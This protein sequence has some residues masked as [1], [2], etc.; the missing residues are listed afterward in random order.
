[1]LA[2]RPA[3]T[4]DRTEVVNLLKE[5]SL[6]YIDPP[7]AYLLVLEENT[8]AGCGRLEDHGQFVMVRPLVVA[9]AYRRQGVGSFILKS[10]MPVD[11]PTLLVARSKAVV[12]YESMGF[13]H[14]SWRETPS[15]CRV[16]C[17]SC[18]DRTGCMPE[19]MLYIPRSVS[20]DFRKGKENGK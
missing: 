19:P 9:A 2:L 11:K 4:E 10:M 18:P 13:S 16:E 5:A 8:I 17:E 15:S 6:V 1:M 3:T 14:T 12:F 7:E 20:S